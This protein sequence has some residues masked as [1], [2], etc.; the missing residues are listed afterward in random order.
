MR[1]S[2]ADGAV[3]GAW[4]PSIDGEYVS[5]LVVASPDVLVV[6]GSFAAIG[7]VPRDSIAALAIPSTGG[8]PSS[9][10]ST[11]ARPPIAVPQPLPSPSRLRAGTTP[12]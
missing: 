8:Q 7:G 4:Q 2:L 9:P 5:Q 6:G 11:H 1:R 10:H 12:P 3:D